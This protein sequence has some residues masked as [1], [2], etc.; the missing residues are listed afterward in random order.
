MAS[1]V[2]P[3][4]VDAIE[5]LLRAAATAH[6][7]YEAAELGGVYDTEWPRWYATHIARSLNEQ[8]LAITTEGPD[9]GTA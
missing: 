6:G 1:R 5:T 9:H 3:A 8:G 2:E 7:E 4:G